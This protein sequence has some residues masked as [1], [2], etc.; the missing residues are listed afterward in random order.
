MTDTAWINEK[1]LRYSLEC[2]LRSQGSITLPEPAVLTGAERTLRWLIAERQAYREPTAGET[3]ALFETAYS[4]PTNSLSLRE[5]QR[6]AQ[7]CLR[8]CRRLRDIVWRCEVLRW[9]FQ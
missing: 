5:E 2:P 4:Q 8:A 3:R 1:A 7:Q 6:R 9:G